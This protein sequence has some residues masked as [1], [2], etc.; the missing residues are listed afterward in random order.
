MLFVE[1]PEP[2]YVEKEEDAHAWKE[3]FSNGEPIGFDT[4]TTGLNIITDR[5][6]FFSIANNEHRICAPV[7]LLKVFKDVLE[8][9]NIE[10]RM[11]NCKYDM[12]MAMNHGVDIQGRIA[13]TI[14]MDFLLDENRHGRHGLKETSKDYLGLR[15]APFST[16]F[17]NLKGGKNQA[18]IMLC[19]MHDC[20]ES[21]DL[22]LATQILAE[23]GK[24]PGANPDVVDGVNRITASIAKGYTYTAKT[25]LAI[26]RKAGVCSKTTGKQGYVVDICK[27]MGVIDKDEEVSTAERAAYDWVLDSAPIQEDMHDDL[28]LDLTKLIP[29]AEDPIEL[30]KL[31]VADYA[32]LDAWAS[33]SLV[34]VMEEEL[35]QV[36][37]FDSGKMYSLLDYYNEWFVDLIKCAFSME[38]TGF[39]VDVDKCKD[40]EAEILR[41]IADI[42]RSAAQAMGKIV[43]LN[44]SA[45]L[46]EYFYAYKNDKWSDIYGNPVKFWSKGGTGGKKSP[47]TGIEALKYF[48]EKGEKV[49]NL[50]L[51]HRKLKKIQEFVHNFPLDA[52]SNGRIHSTLNIVGARTGRWS[53]RN[54]NMQNIPSKGELGSLVRSLF[55]PEKG[56]TLIVADYGQLEMRIMAHFADE[57]EMI[58][59]ISEGKDLHSMTAALAG[60]YDYEAVVAAKKKKDKGAKLTKEEKELCTVRR[61]MKAVGFGLNYGIGAVKLGRQLD[62]PIE[63]TVVRGRLREKCPEGQALI[64]DY[65][66]VY[67]NINRYIE[68]VKEYAN[69]HQY[70]QTISG[71]YRRLPEINSREFWIKAKAQRQ[72]GNTVIQGSAVD[73]MN[74]AVLKIFNSKRLKKLGVTVLLQ[75][76]DELIFELPDDKETIAAAMEIIQ[77]CM[78]NA[79]PLKVP[80]EAEP[81]VGPTWE[82]AK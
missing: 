67:K 12:H 2:I 63:E 36:E 16:V 79:W 19:K 1:T 59:A 49:A 73:I 28:L 64:N 6:K 18:V 45:Q 69:K 62:L 76:H 58:K 30:L 77:D 57:T 41:D 10:V 22:T 54:P 53:S 46:K 42:E 68:N 9:P 56:K 20:I 23:L 75:V 34:D 8:D 48:A 31:I 72:A 74:A 35:S 32:S 52:D 39:K 47:S 78:E 7:R 70:V 71:R 27:Y 14:C 81:G 80:L 38:R 11:T 3:V 25:L 51:E 50:L 55:I 61:N 44:S 43:N 26:G 5:V 21:K 40:V 24:V 66:G 15:M 4:E 60:G 82:D 17:G 29:H 33:Y 13:D 37:L 65:F